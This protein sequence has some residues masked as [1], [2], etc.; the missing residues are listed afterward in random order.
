[1]ETITEQE[2]LQPGQS[3]SKSSSDIKKDKTSAADVAED[4]DDPFYGMH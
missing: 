4:D 3:V 2:Y 1:M